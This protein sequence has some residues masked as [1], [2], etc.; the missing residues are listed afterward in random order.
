MHNKIYRYP[1]KPTRQKNFDTV[2]K[3]TNLS[4]PILFSPFKTPIS[5]PH[6]KEG[7]TEFNSDQR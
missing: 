2:K 3:Q 5:D 7:L 6:E 1:S 4:E